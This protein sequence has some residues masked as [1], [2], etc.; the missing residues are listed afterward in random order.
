MKEYVV[1][2]RHITEAKDSIDGKRHQRWLYFAGITDCIFG[3]TSNWGSKM[4]AMK[5]SEADAKAVAKVF[6]AN[7]PEVVEA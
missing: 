1:R 5:M 4:N 6:R 7:K 3:R 2:Y